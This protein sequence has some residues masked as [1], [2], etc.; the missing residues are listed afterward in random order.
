MTLEKF[1][2]YV[3]TTGYSNIEPTYWMNIPLNENNGTIAHDISGNSN[4]V[5]N[6]KCNLDNRRSIKNP[7]SN[8]RL[9]NKYCDGFVYNCE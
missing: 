9:H 5:N 1:I 6:N 4:D 2:E 7:N 8:H 3:N